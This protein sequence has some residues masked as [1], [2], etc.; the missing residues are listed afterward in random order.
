MYDLVIKNAD[1][2]DGTGA[3]RFKGDIAV[4]GK[5]IVMLGEIGDSKAANTID[6]EGLLVAPGFIDAHTHD[7]RMMLSSPQM[8][9]KVSQGVTTVVGGN[10]GVSLSPLKGI[11]PPPPMNLLGG[12]EWYRFSS[13]REYRGE[14][15]TAGVA[16]NCAMLV[17]HSTLRTGAMKNLGNAAS[18]SEIDT[19]TTVM[20]DALED[21]CIGLSTGLDYP[22]ACA[23]PT[24]ELVTMARELAGH[25]AMYVS[26]IRDEGDYLLEAV[27]EA[28]EISGVSQVP[29]VISHHKSAGQRNWGKTRNTLEMINRARS[30]QT[31]HFDVYPYIAS[32][33]V[34]LTQFIE[35]PDKVKITWSEPY[36]ELGGVY[37]DKICDQWSCDLE[38]AV[39]RL[40]PAGAIYFEMDENE[41]QDLLRQPQ[42]MVGSD[43]LPH[44]PMPH[45]RLWGTFPRVVGYYARELGLFSVEQAIHQMTGLTA[46]VFGLEKRGEIKSGNYAD[47]VIFDENRILDLADFDNPIQPSAGIHSVYVN[48]QVVWEKGAVTGKRP[49]RWLERFVA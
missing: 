26:H 48:G 16:T 29:L 18:N 34:L 4:Q 7:D 5:I 2:V 39:Q 40:Q 15:E 3:S 9:P 14:L 6:A 45:P 20:V 35:T 22:P 28:L 31:V 49:G 24:S 38:S 13:I 8:E 17:G 1:I 12:Q 19:M 44:D 43:G 25:N 42:T 37:L 41:M 10:C 27:E 47:L 21:G 36:P 46:S 23:A 32:S 30:N 33:S 11:D